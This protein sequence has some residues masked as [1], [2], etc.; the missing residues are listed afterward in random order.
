MARRRNW[1]DRSRLLWR[2]ANRIEAFQLRSFG[3]SPMSLLKRR[4]VLVIEA[5]GRKT[6]RQRSPPS[7][8]GRRTRVP[9]WWAAERGG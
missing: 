7:P 4:D 3:I 9:T 5:R 1:V 8:T 2:V 6:G